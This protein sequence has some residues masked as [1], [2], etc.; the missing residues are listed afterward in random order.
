MHKHPYPRLLNLK[1]VLLQLQTPPILLAVAAV[2]VFATPQDSAKAPHHA[3]LRA[4]SAGRLQLEDPN[5][6]STIE[7][8]SAPQRAE[9]LHLDLSRTVS[10]A[11]P[12]N[13][14]ID[15]RDSQPEREATARAASVE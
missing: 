9:R 1:A 5:F 13:Q 10:P 14:V 11:A 3:Y 8:R 12:P 6:A 7:M 2:A 4:Q 15:D